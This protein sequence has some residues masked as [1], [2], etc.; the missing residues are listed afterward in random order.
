MRRSVRKN[1]VPVQ[2]VFPKARE[3]IG[4]FVIYWEGSIPTNKQFKQIRVLEGQG[5]LDEEAPSESCWHYTVYA[6]TGESIWLPKWMY[7]C[8]TT[9]F[10]R[11]H[12]CTVILNEVIEQLKGRVRIF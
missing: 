12:G 10:D 1:N 6:P 7:S 11:I 2:S 3:A 5:I 8:L 4:E 9:K